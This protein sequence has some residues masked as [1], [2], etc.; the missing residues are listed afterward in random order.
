MPGA[1]ANADSKIPR[2]DANADSKVLGTDGNMD[3]EVPSV[4][5]NADSK[6]P[7]ADAHVDLRPIA[8]G[9]DARGPYGRVTWADSSPGFGG[10]VGSGT[11][12]LRSEGGVT[13]LELAGSNYS[14]RLQGMNRDLTATLTG[15]ETLLAGTY[16]CGQDAVAGYRIDSYLSGTIIG[17]LCWASTPTADCP[18]QVA[19]CTFTLDEQIWP[20]CFDANAKGSFSMTLT[21]DAGTM[22]ITNGTFDLPIVEPVPPS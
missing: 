6:V 12:M 4:D 16:V 2:A 21:G 19:S 13:R 7:G 22:S 8:C 20:G 14:G 1:D 18:G 17:T 10:F 11:A 5:A 9:S 3:V 15:G